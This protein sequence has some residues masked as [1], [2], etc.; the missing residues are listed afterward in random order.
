MN[1][2]TNLLEHMDTELEFTIKFN[3]Q[4]IK[5]YK[6][7]FDQEVQ[8]DFDYDW[9]NTY[10]YDFIIKNNQFTIEFDDDAYR[11]W[12]DDQLVLT[13]KSNEIIPVN[14]IHKMIKLDDEKYILITNFVWTVDVENDMLNKILCM[15]ANY[16]IKYYFPDESNEITIPIEQIPEDLIEKYGNDFYW[17]FE[18]GNESYFVSVKINKLHATLFNEHSLIIPEYNKKRWMMFIKFLN[19]TKI[20]IEY[21]VNQG[22]DLEMYINKKKVMHIVDE[23][24]YFCR[25]VDDY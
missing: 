19:E 9:Q 15:K 4:I 23:I 24:G 7:N 18:Y 25:P 5:T 1:I 14:D 6:F 2:T 22:H 11:D 12:Q 8:I 17:I 13:Q 16:V 20:P 10:D 3:C 21:E